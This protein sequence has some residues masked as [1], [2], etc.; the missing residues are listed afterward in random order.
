M[1]ES[2]S[3]LSGSEHRYPLS[4]EFI[5]LSKSTHICLVEPLPATIGPGVASVDQLAIYADPDASFFVECEV[6]AAVH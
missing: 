4:S 1:W 2:L 6:V 3:D 5:L